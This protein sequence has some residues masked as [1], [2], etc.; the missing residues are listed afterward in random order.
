RDTNITMLPEWEHLRD[1]IFYVENP[2]DIEALAAQM[3]AMLQISEDEEMA[4]SQRIRATMNRYRWPN[5]I[6]EYQAVINRA[7]KSA[8]ISS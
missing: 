1:D 7:R 4:R 8:T 3:R 2:Q 5:L 6:R